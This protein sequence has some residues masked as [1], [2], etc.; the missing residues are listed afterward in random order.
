MIQIEKFVQSMPQMMTN[1]SIITLGPVE[2]QHARAGLPKSSA[3]LGARTTDMLGIFEDERRR[4]GPI[5]ANPAGTG[6]IFPPAALRVLDVARAMPAHARLA[7]E[8]IR[9]RRLRAVILNRP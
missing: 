8:K 3:L 6:R 1:F 4:S 9:L 7:G 2:Y 5:S